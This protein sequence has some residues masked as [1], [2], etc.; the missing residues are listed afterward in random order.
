M[1]DSNRSVSKSTAVARSGGEEGFYHGPNGTVYRT[2]TVL[3]RETS[4]PHLTPS[5][6]AYAK[7]FIQPAAKVLH[8]WN[9][10]QFLCPSTVESL[11]AL[12]GGPLHALS[13]HSLGN[14]TLKIQDSGAAGL[15]VRSWVFYSDKG[16]FQEY[17][18]KLGKLT[19]ILFDY[20]CWDEYHSW[21]RATFNRL[22]TVFEANLRA[23]KVEILGPR[24]LRGEMDDA[25]GEES[26][27][28]EA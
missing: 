4:S 17:F 15:T 25:E 5:F 19:L 2:L 28:V 21:D 9:G 6:F 27:D 10:F 3:K 12:T 20:V 8:D 11:M 23:R 1:F 18:P 7:G 14:V 16:L 24:I 22:K 13:N 26:C